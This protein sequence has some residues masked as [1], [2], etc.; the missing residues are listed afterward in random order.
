MKTQYSESTTTIKYY[1]KV[2]MGGIWGKIAKSHLKY[3][4][5]HFVKQ[6]SF[7]IKLVRSIFKNQMEGYNV[8]CK[9]PAPHLLDSPDP[10]ARDKYY[11]LLLYIS[12]V[13][14]EYSVCL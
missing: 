1:I 14:I 6:L 4:L 3:L 10:S 8:K 2:R 11:K 12:S 7:F 9:Y 13:F 5:L